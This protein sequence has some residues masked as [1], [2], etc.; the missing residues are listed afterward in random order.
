[1][2]PLPPES[3]AAGARIPVETK[4]SGAYTPASTLAEADE[5]RR[6]R[7]AGICSCIRPPPRRTRWSHWSKYGSDVIVG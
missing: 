4:E 3:A 1:V 7:D 6:N 5:A 2:I